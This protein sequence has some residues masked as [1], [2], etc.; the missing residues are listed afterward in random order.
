MIT[1]AAKLIFTHDLKFRSNQDDSFIKFHPTVLENK[2]YPLVPDNLSWQILQSALEIWARI[3][4]FVKLGAILH[5]SFIIGVL[6]TGNMFVLTVSHHQTQREPGVKINLLL[7]ST[8][9]TTSSINI[10]NR[11]CLFDLVI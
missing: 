8:I 10:M 6:T 11:I 2:D 5:I 1:S 3:C 4:W 7:H 9:F